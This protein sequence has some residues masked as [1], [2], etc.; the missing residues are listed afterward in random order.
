MYLRRQRSLEHDPYHD[1]A[2][3]STSIPEK[4]KAESPSTHSTRAKGSWLLKIDKFSIL[5]TEPYF[6]IRYVSKETPHLAYRAVAMAKPGPSPMVPKV[7][8]S[9]RWRGSWRGGRRRRRS[10]DGSPHLAS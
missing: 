4:P 6:K 1:L 3:V 7:P 9:R 10:R 8:A 2:M 5:K